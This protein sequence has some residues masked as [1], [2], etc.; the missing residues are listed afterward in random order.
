MDGY[1]S[2]RCG[3]TAALS[4]ISGSR[5]GMASSTVAVAVAA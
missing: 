2:L 5:R 3:L 1:G 4:G